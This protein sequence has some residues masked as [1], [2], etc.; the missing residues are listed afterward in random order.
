MCEWRQECRGLNIDFRLYSLFMLQSSR[1]SLFVYQ[2]KFAKVPILNNSHVSLGLPVLGT[3]PP[4]II[5]DS[6]VNPTKII[7]HLNSFHGITQTLH[8]HGAKI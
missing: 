3:F 4:P 1:H 7:V 8:T 6:I 2:F 5:P